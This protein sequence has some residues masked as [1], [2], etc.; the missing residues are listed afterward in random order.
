MQ[1]TQRWIRP[2]NIVK[3]DD[4][5]NRDDRF[6][7]VIIKGMINWLNTH[8]LL[9]D[10]PI[11]H[12]LYNTG[13]SYMYMESNG[14]EFSWVETSGED[15]MY[16]QMPRCI[17]EMTGIDIPMEELTSPYAHGTYERR[18][19]DNIQGF[20][21][22]I[23]RIPVEIDINL[24][25]VLANFNESIILAE[26][27]INN[28]MF[29]R[30]YTVAFLGQNLKCS[31][32]FPPNFNI[33]LNHID[34]TDSTTNQ[35]NVQLQLKIFTNYPAI[36]ESTEV[37]NNSIVSTFSFGQSMATWTKS[38]PVSLTKTNSDNTKTKIK[39]Y[40][41]DD[42]NLYDENGNCVEDD[43]A[44]NLILDEFGKPMTKM[45]IIKAFNYS[46][47][48]N[49]SSNLFR[50]TIDNELDNISKLMVLK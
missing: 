25:Y 43:I 4:L 22:D 19:G 27:L 1:T 35:K 48:G 5:Y 24:K 29:Q 12:F 31:I 34:M 44:N 16:M 10:K 18:N 41:K 37:S 9:Y 8:I 26:E 14:Y 7:S 11:N 40:M 17:V 20:N 33:E 3:F 2:W 47:S 49:V 42:N 23:R 46:K 32:E 36:D 45:Q 39:L 38:H 6:F 28:V 30:Y 15:Q 21:A 13:S 50:G